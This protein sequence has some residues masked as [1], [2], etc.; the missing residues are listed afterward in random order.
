MV[1]IR[2]I[3]HLLLDEWLDT[4][5]QVL[6]PGAKIGQRLVHEHSAGKEK[7]LD[8]KVA[9]PMQQPFGTAHVYLL[10]EGTVIPQ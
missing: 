1:V 4:W 9:Q 6:E 5:H 10:V 2:E 8:L 3:D 7:L